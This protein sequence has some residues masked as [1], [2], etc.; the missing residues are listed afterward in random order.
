MS[1]K[2]LI[3]NRKSITSYIKLS[4]KTLLFTKTGKHPPKIA[5]AFYALQIRAEVQFI[6]SLEPRDGVDSRSYYYDLEV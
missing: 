6:D 1:Y 3:C 4:P 5:M 2:Y